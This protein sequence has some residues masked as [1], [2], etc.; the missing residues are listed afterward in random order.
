MGVRLRRDGEAMMT[1]FDRTHAKTERAR[2]LRREMTDVEKK[3]WRRLCGDQLGVSFRRQHPIGAYV[4]DF[5][6]APAGLVVELD[7]DQHGTEEGLASDARRTAF[8]ASK[9]L[10]VLRFWNHE[11]RTNLDG[12]VETIWIT[13]QSAGGETPTPALPLA[14]GGRRP[15][16]ESCGSTRRDARGEFPAEEDR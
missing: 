5:Y 1:R 14:G 13:V 4:V 3:L 10:R 8:L 2:R 6:C 16:T 11:A 12:V 15:A 7:G 9:G